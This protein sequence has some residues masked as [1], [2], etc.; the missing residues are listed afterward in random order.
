MAVLVERDHFGIFGKMNAGKSTVMNLLTQQ[1]SS[2]VDSHPGTTA[3]T[4]VTLIEIHGI[5]PVK[6][7]DTAGA[8]EQSGLGEKKRHKLFNDLKACDLMILVIDPSST[9]LAAEQTLLD[10]A[11]AADKQVLVVY[12]LFKPGDAASTVRMETA[13][14]LL[15]FYPKL[16][17]NA[18]QSA[19]RSKLINFIKAHY[20][21]RHTTVPLLPFLER[22]RYYLL[23][24][25]MDEETPPGRYLR[26]QA[27]VEE[28]I[29]RHWGWPVSFRPDLAKARGGDAG[30]AS[31]EKA[32]FDAVCARLGD[33]LAGVI[34]D[35]QA[36]DV[37]HRWVPSTMPLTTFSIVMINYMSRGR[38]SDFVQ[39]LRD[40]NELKAG[41]RILIVEACNHSRIAE[42]IGTVQIPTAIA[43]HFPGVTVEHNFGREFQDN[44]DLARYRLVI[45]CG[46][47]MISPQA[48]TARVRDLTQIGVPFTNYGLFLSALQ[49]KAALRRVLKPW[50]LKP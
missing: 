36:M 46:G 21:A 29:T 2:I 40:V 31:A 39:G 18:D 30:A 17:I 44:P 3:D 5:G 7:M 11:R 27:M 19:E 22:D 50:G 43:R 37:M 32:R 48:L 24:I 47:C 25:P 16:A 12:N 45:H 6:L 13:L 9:T 23:N 10:A 26:P 8:D 42:D 14:P 33:R 34:T 38:L 1:E 15:R 49:G 35:S 4:K 28:Y 20:A 41:D